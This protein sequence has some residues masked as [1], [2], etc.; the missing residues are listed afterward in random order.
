MT[1]P[2]H[3]RP[4]TAP[5]R[6]QGRSPRLSFLLWPAVLLP[7]A[8]LAVMARPLA[9]DAP[10]LQ[11]YGGQVLG[12]GATLCLIGCLAVTPATRMVRWKRAAWWRKWLGM[13]V[14]FT[15]AAGLAIAATG[16]PQ[17]QL[18]MRVSGSSREWTGTVIV[19]A[20]I[21]LAL[22][23]NKYSQ[24]L[25]GTHWKAW[26]R[27]LTWAAWGVLAVHM[28]TLAAWQTEVAFIMAS[29]PLLAARIPAARRDISGWQ[30]GGYA[31][32]ARWVLTGLAAGVFACGT[33][34]L[35][36]M[37]VVACAQATRLS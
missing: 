11:A 23:S 7:L 1:A 3:A 28:V 14:F 26:Q 29:G 36:W 34:A 24:K 31:D 10:R 13:C 33:A 9:D 18:G 5:A 8:P 30:K 27:R 6:R 37:E 4:R 20:L 16:G 17:S 32:G 22:T 19:L 2:A 35:T 25:L 15:G 21:P 12:L